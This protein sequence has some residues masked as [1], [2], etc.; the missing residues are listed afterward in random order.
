MLAATALLATALPLG[1]PA[2]AGA[3]A[4][5]APGVVA[6]REQ[7]VPVYT[8]S[9]SAVF[10]GMVTTSN[11]EPRTDGQ[12]GQ[13]FTQAVTVE[14]VYAGSVTSDQVTV[15]TDKIP[16]QCTLG[17]LVTGAT[18]VFFATGDGEPWIAAGGGGTAVS[19]PE[20][21]AQVEG[22][23]GPGRLPVAPAKESATFSPVTVSE[24][25]R[26]SRL[27]APGAALVIAGLLGLLVVGRLGRR[28]A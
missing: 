22:L 10:T 8:R 4:G 24:P 14:R 16:K 6:C 1:L 15:Q 19:S 3:P 13:V 23:L 7:S 9:A 26:L 28:R 20:L 17:R 12:A 11:G 5:A 25:T 18:Y 2:L 21:V 27:A